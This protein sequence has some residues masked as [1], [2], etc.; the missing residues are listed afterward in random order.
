MPVA[1]GSLSVMTGGTGL[2]MTLV[3]ARLLEGGGSVTS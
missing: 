3:G 1:K 2:A